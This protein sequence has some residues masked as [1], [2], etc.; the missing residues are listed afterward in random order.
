[1]AKE[2]QQTVVYQWTVDHGKTAIIFLNKEQT[3][4]KLAKAYPDCFY[5]VTYRNIEAFNKSKDSITK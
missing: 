3:D 5:S 4:E 2:T 1:M